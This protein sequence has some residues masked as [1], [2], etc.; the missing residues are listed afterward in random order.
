MEIGCQ[1]CI[2]HHLERRVGASRAGA[3]SAFLTQVSRIRESDCDRRRAVGIWL[4]VKKVRYFLLLV[5]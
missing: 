2:L 3:S 5:D 4:D 1:S